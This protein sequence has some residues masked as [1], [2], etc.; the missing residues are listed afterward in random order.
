MLRRRLTA[1]D[2]LRPGRTARAHSGTH[3]YLMVRTDE[4]RVRGSIQLTLP[5]VQK[6]V[7]DLPDDPGVDDLEAHRVA[8]QDAYLH[9]VS[10]SENG[11]A[12]TF[13]P[14]KLRMLGRDAKRYVV[15]EIQEA[16]PG[17]FPRSLTVSAD[18]LVLD[19]HHQQLIVVARRTLG[20]G[21]MR[22]RVRDELT[23]DHHHTTRTVELTAPTAA[24]HARASLDEGLRRFRK[25]QERA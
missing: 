4:A 1:A 13:T 16:A 25:R 15:M 11:D 23:V 24:E 6:H 22:R 19:D 18:R 7:A 21:S 8:I 10:V 14:G 20:W 9:R 12:V 5:Y 17:T 2:L 3:H